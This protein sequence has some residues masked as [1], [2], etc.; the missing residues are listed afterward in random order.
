MDPDATLRRIHAEVHEVLYGD[1]PAPKELARLIADLDA[2]L[3]GGGPLPEAW[4]VP[5]DRPAGV[6]GKRLTHLNDGGR[7]R[8]Y[9]CTRGPGHDG[10]H[11]D[12]GRFA[13]SGVRDRGDGVL[14]PCAEEAHRG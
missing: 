7:P 5:G 2:H 10:P 6:C 11:A 1:K 8:V 12:R 3:T 4:A 9:V 14:E 13:W